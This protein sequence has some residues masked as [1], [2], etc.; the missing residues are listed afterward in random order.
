MAAIGNSP[1]QQAFTPAIDYFSGNGST[2]AFTLS[3]PVA[4]VAQVQVTIDNVAQNPSSAY[5]VSANTITFTSAPLSGTNN[6]YVYYTSPITQVIAPG[7]GTVTTTSLTSGLT[8]TSPTITGGAFNGTLGATTPSTVAATSITASTTLNVTGAATLTADAT[9]SGLTVGKGGGAVATNTAVGASA[10]SANQAGGTNN[11]A[12]GNAALDANTTGDANTAVGDDALGANTTASGNTA[13]GYQAGYTNATGASQ[14]F[15]GY[16][17]GRTS[18]PSSGGQNIGVGNGALYSLTTGTSNTAIG[19]TSG[20]DITTGSKNTIIG[21]YSGN[22]GSVDIRTSSNNIVLSDGDGNPRFYGDS[23]GYFLFGTARTSPRGL[24][25]IPTSGGSGGAPLAVSRGGD[26]GPMVNF[27][28]MNSTTTI[29]GSIANAS[30]TSTTYNTSSDYRLKENIA[31]MTGALAT[32]AQLKP[33]TYKWKS[34]GSDGQ[35]FIAHELQA[36]VPDCVTGEKDAV[37]ENGDMKPQGIDTSFLV[38]T[39]TA[40]IQEL[41]AINDTQAAT[42]NALTARIVALENR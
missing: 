16:L 34:N 5:T 33:V 6:I 7:Q 35:G 2:T 14:T 37:D 10:L 38:A 25:D 17:A 27:Y 28:S 3:R 26:G 31:P 39:L 13:V 15:I 29:I 18:N 11:T 20:Y 30:N 23:S 1:T 21:G 19:P 41:K 12:I 40:A 4:S 8:L 42:I 36:V 24:L 9:I 32:V 22:Q